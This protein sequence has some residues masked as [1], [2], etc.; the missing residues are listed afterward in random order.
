MN[1]PRDLYWNSSLPDYWPIPEIRCTPLKKTWESQKCYPHF[2]L[3]IPQILSTVLVA[4]L[5]KIWECP[6]F[7]IVFSTRNGNSQFL[8]RLPWQESHTGI[9]LSTVIC[10]YEKYLP[11]ALMDFNQSWVINATWEP[12]FVDEVKGHISRS[13]V[14]GGQVVS[15]QMSTCIVHKPRRQVTLVVRGQQRILFC[16][17]HKK[18]GIPNSLLQFLEFPFF[19][20]KIQTWEFPIFKT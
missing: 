2:S 17:W 3:G 14:I 1:W 16:F 13:K 6:N 20:V 9:A 5:K 7:W 4:R 11:H 10:C 15:C 8:C 19:K 12:S 18:M